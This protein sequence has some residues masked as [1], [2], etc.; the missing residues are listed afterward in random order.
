MQDTEIEIQVKV[1][2]IKPLVEFLK[3]KGTFKYKNHQIDEY[4]VPSHRD[5]TQ[6]RPVMEWLRLRDNDGRYE[7]NYKHWLQDEKDAGHFGDE[8]E[9][10]VVNIDQLRKIFAVLDFK[11]LVVVDK[12][13]QAWEYGDYEI[14]IDRVKGLGEFVEIELKSG[15]GDKRPSAIVKEMVKFLG[16]LKVG[17]IE[18]NNG[19]YAFMML[20][21]DEVEF[22]E[23]E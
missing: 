1:E 7:I 13:R 8:F 20:F 19:G 9:S 16:E 11:S 5:F 2:N 18:K 22:E 17:K 21:P 4:F 23:V 15:L 3:E 12:T 6:E 10:E 14:C